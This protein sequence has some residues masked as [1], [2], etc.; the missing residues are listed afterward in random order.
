MYQK[1]TQRGAITRVVAELFYVTELENIYAIIHIH[2][3]SD[4]QYRSPEKKK[5]FVL[6]AKHN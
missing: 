6:W 3:Y 2:I 1:K 4:Q 5:Q